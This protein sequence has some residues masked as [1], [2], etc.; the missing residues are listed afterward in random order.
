[1]VTEYAGAFDATLRLVPPSLPVPASIL[2][3]EDE[4]LVRAMGVGLFA[5][6]GFRPI[7]AANSDEALERLDADTEVQVLFTDVD[8]PGTIDGLALAWQ[9]RDRWPDIGIIIV[10]G[11][12]MP[13]FREL[14]AGCLFHR[15]PYDP[16]GVIRHAR[17]LTAA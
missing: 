6:A 3:V 4:V 9:A 14:P 2:I 12:P 13:P 8:L 16:E 7:E 11:R 5:D 10:S 15:K 1:M 17:E